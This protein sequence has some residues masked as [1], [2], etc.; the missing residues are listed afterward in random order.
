MYNR[1]EYLAAPGCVGTTR[2]GGAFGF[3]TT[4]YNNYHDARKLVAGV[5]WLSGDDHLAHRPHG[6][7]QVCVLASLSA[8][9][10][11]DR[12]QARAFA[13]LTG[14][15]DQ[16][17]R[18]FEGTTASEHIWG[19]NLCSGQ[20][21]VRLCPVIVTHY[22][23]RFFPFILLA[24]DRIYYWRHAHRGSGRLGI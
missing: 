16:A 24:P 9:R 14:T 8:V 23:L 6:A 20:S 18:V 7:P 2:S 17:R 3:T 4:M 11:V 22:S 19:C 12:R 21:G 15:V 13:V 1:L 10:G 5:R